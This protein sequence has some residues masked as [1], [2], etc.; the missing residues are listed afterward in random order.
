LIGGG[1]TQ[2]NE[3]FALLSYTTNNLGD[4]I[5]SV[6]ARQFLPSVDLLIDRDDWSTVPS[7]PAGVFKVIL[8]G[9]FTHAPDSWPPPD[10]L[11]PLPI[12]MHIT[13]ERYRPTALR[14][15]AQAL[16]EGDS[17]KFLQ[18]HQPIGGRDRWTARLLREHGVESYFSACLTLTFGSP[19]GTAR[20]DY[21]CAVDLDDDTDRYLTGHA[22][23]PILRLSH[24]DASGGLFERRS[25][26][27]HRLLSLYAQAKCVVTTRLH[28][29]LP[30]LALG[31]P[32]LFVNQAVDQYRLSGLVELLRCC[33]AKTLKAGAVDFDFDRPPANGEAH[34]VLRDN[35]IARAQAFTG[36][37]MQPLAIIP[38]DRIDRDDGN[39]GGP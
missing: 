26:K 9:W 19:A 13:S 16:L 25:A 32:V 3:K 15:P 12:S 14:A 35:L 22:R 2:M 11:Q 7:R 28:C 37:P 24:R 36:V 27:A 21:I 20:G 33:D 34:L 31:T 29:A 30:S 10:F 1:A 38:Y 17:L 5:Q 18:R 23:A 4:E 8:N 39:W 6:A